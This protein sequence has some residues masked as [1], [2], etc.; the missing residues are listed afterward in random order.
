MKNWLGLGD[1][2]TNVGTPSLEVAESISF[3]VNGELRRR[4]GL[5]K[6]SIEGGLYMTHIK[7]LI[8]GGFLVTVQS[9][10]TIDAVSV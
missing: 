5:T 4:A 6:E 1:D 7:S 3:R 9:D 8:T 2:K 10:G